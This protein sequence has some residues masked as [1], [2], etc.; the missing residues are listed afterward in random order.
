MT[1]VEMANGWFRALEV[2]RANGSQTKRPVINLAVTMLVEMCKAPHR[3]AKPQPLPEA[4]NDL[5]AQHGIDR[6]EK[7]AQWLA[8]MGAVVLKIHSVQT[9]PMTIE[10]ALSPPEPLIKPDPEQ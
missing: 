6:L 4:F 9:K 7:A 1:D 5:M 2:E 8:R 3:Y 10:F